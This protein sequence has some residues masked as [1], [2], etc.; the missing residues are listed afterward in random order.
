[1]KTLDGAITRLSR[2]PRFSRAFRKLK[3]ISGGGTL[4]AMVFLTE[5]GDLDRFANRR[6]PVLRP[7]AAPSALRLC[8]KIDFLFQVTLL[9]KAH[10]FRS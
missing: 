6:Q 2:S 3:L 5:L 10:T 1:M 8:E 7:K 9:E 4:S